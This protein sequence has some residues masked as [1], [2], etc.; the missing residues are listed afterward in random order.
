MPNGTAVSKLQQRLM[1]AVYACQNGGKCPSRKIRR[2]SK[3]M[4]RNDVK[5]FASTKHDRL[6]DKYFEIVKEELI[7]YLKEIAIP[8]GSCGKQCPCETPCEKPN[9]TGYIVNGTAIQMSS[10]SVEKSS[11]P[12][13]CKCGV[14]GHLKLDSPINDKTPLMPP[15]QVTHFGNTPKLDGSNSKVDKSNRLSLLKKILCLIKSKTREVA[16]HNGQSVTLYT[17]TL[18]GENIVFYIKNGNVIKE[19]KI[20]KK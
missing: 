13:H 3:K 9:P 7:K 20:S 11:K 8:C 18:V 10:N 2:L 17:P 12:T 14:N 15:N 6:P 19:C 16:T 4:D 1:G 5:D